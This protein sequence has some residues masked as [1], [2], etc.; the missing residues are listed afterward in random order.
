MK[1]IKSA[2]CIIGLI[3]VFSFFLFTMY[4]NYSERELKACYGVINTID[5]Y[6][7]DIGGSITFTNKDDTTITI[8]SSDAVLYS[9][10]EMIACMLPVYRIYG[11][12]LFIPTI[13][14]LIS[15]VC[16]YIA[17]KFCPIFSKKGY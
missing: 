14:F 17:F 5:V 15:C 16:V 4:L 7:N 10:G 11:R 9:E 3:I 2:L 1:Y 8:Y 13:L 12:S 6:E